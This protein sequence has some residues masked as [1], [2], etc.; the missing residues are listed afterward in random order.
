[1]EAREL[2]KTMVRIPSVNPFRYYRHPNGKDYVGFGAEQRMNEFVEQAL[3]S[4][5][6]EVSRQ[7]LHQDVTVT[8][9]GGELPVA[10]RWN[11]LGVR[12]PKGQW[13]GKSLL[14]FGHTDTVD[15]KQGWQT[16]PFVVTERVVE[17]Q[18]RWYGLGANDMKAGLAAILQAIATSQSSHYAVKVAFL[19]DEEFYS[20]GAELLC[21]SSFLDDV[22]I[23]IAPEIGDDSSPTVSEPGGHQL[24][25]IGR[26]GRVEYDF[27]VVG[28]ACHGADAF[29]HPDAVNAVHESIK[30]QAALV[31]RCTR[32]RKVFG[33]FGAE[34]LNSAYISSQ[35]GGE[36]ML[37]VPDRAAFVFDRTFTPDESPDVE[38]TELRALIE[39]LQRDGVV[40]SRAAVSVEPRA[41]PTPPCKPYVFSPELPEIKRVLGAVAAHSARFSMMIGRSVADEN[42]VA[43]RGI[44]TVILGPSGSGSHTPEEWVDPVSVER[45]SRIFSAL[46]RAS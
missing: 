43:L 31:E 16:D 30:L 11:V 24:V 22:V 5:G 15:V 6:F 17:G 8:E 37:S 38:L 35:S 33:A 7:F 20:F 26:T 42:R 28:K 14:F 4:A 34:V 13:N 44:P 21:A 10:A 41:R 45:I 32:L 29:I 1:M 46:I 40:D 27:T 19:V 3:R 9:A 2:L 25:G 12:Y 18:T 36:P 39:K 23:A